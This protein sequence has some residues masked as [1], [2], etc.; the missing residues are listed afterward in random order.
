MAS[1]PVGDG[2][3]SSVEFGW[4]SGGAL[5]GQRVWSLWKSG[6]RAHAEINAHVLGYELRVYMS[7]SLLFK[8][9]HPTREA[10]EREAREMEGD[11]R[12]K[13]WTDQPEPLYGGPR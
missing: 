8:S 1:S 12:A 6:T 9:L 4:P 11:A 3:G 13:A 5:K 7:G 2:R 10:A